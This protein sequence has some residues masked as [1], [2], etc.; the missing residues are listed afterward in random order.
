MTADELSFAGNVYGL[1]MLSPYA[2]FYTNSKGASIVGKEKWYTMTPNDVLNKLYAMI[3]TQFSYSTPFGVEKFSE[4]LPNSS[5]GQDSVVRP[6][7]SL[8]SCVIVT[9]IGTPEDPYV[10]DYDDS[11]K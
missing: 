7:I 1:G 10:V 3:Y 11:C 5:Y 2:W 4:L 8:S 9:G 6:V